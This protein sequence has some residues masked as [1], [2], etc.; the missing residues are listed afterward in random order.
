M[1]KCMKERSFA[2]PDKKKLQSNIKKRLADAYEALLKN[3]MKKL[4]KHLRDN[5]KPDGKYGLWYLGHIRWD[6]TIK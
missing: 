2:D 1:A 6:I 5:I 4:D 3:G